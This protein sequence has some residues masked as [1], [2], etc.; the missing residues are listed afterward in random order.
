MTMSRLRGPMAHEK[1]SSCSRGSASAGAG[2]AH[3]SH[4]APPSTAAQ[5]QPASGAQLGAE[6]HAGVGGAGAA[7]ADPGRSGGT[8]SGSG[9]GQGGGGGQGDDQGASGA[10]STQ[11]QA[12]SH[13]QPAPTP[14]PL[15]PA[16]GSQTNQ[17]GG[18]GEAGS[19]R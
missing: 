15:P 19:D 1:R 18:G 8:S 9:Q 12:P 13:H 14:A 4:A 7:G 17:P 10:S 3:G 5:E 11:K 2:D 6:S 16:A